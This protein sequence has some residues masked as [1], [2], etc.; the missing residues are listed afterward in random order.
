VNTAEDGRDE[1]RLERGLAS[2]V[3][4]SCS[5]Y[6]LRPTLVPGV[7]NYSPKRVASRACSEVS[8]KHGDHQKR[9]QRH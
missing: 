8:W 2:G 5:F 9:H 1:M 4:V 3:I 7:S 6:F